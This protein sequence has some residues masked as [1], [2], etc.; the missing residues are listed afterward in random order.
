[1]TIYIAVAVFVALM[2]VGTILDGVLSDKQKKT[3]WGR[4]LVGLLPSPYNLM[5]LYTRVGDNLED[6]TKA[7]AMSGLGFLGISVI[8]H[9]FAW[10]ADQQV[11]YG[12]EY[13]A[14]GDESYSF[15]QSVGGASLIQLT[16]MF[17]GGTTFRLWVNG[18]HNAEDHKFLFRVQAV[19]ALI[20]F[21]VT[22][23][24]SFQTDKIA[25][26]RGMEMQ[27]KTKN[28][29]QDGVAG[30]TEM[31]ATE[32]GQLK[33]T[34]ATD[35][36]RIVKSFQAVESDLQR[37]FIS[38]SIRY[39]KVEAGWAAGHINNLRSKKNKQIAKERKKALAKVEKVRSKNQPQIDKLMAL[40]AESVA[41]AI[42]KLDEAEAV[43]KDNV[44][45]N[46]TATKGKNI[47]L[48]L[49]GLFFSLALQ[50]YL[51]GAI[52]TEREKRENEEPDAGI[53]DFDGAVPFTVGDLNAGIDDD[54]IEAEEV[55]DDFV[56]PIIKGF[57]VEIS[58]IPESRPQ[59][60]DLFDTHSKPK[61]DAKEIPVK[62]VKRPKR[63]AKVGSFNALEANSGQIES[64]TLANGEIVI[65]Y[66]GKSKN[67][68]QTY[69]KIRSA[70]R[71][72]VKKFKDAKSDRS[73]NTNLQWIRL[74]EER[75]AYVERNQQTDKDMPKRKNFN[76][77]NPDAELFT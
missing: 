24:L 37:A 8:V 71:N 74:F 40:K 44:E 39:S 38:D 16:L 19:L 21:I 77:A 64:K 32:L 1:M 72:R 55:D 26:K 46:A 56:P 7:H 30:K 17:C 73:R 65:K 34:I 29:V 66:Y 60:I 15:W 50:F 53:S 47:I 49:V 27:A 11:L 22:A 75:L 3:K 23:Y 35:S 13:V 14:T 63:K 52:K 61:E 20:A 69:G 51:K 43:T 68:W 18:L 58:D 28:E 42:G 67:E 5:K 57:D 6:F 12:M 25:L 9:A 48:N 45:Y 59:Q 36:L 31:L 33:Q 76:P 41:G 10:W 54:V 62:E 70:L 4:V 2:I